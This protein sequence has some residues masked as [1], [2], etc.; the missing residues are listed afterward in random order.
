MHAP[1]KQKEI[2]R[3]RSKQRSIHPEGEKSQSH[4]SE[5]GLGASTLSGAGALW[6]LEEVQEDMKKEYAISTSEWLS[7]ILMGIC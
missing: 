3:R 4:S 1:A 2:Q 7:H 6:T 5:N